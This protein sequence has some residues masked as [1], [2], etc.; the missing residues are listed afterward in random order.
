MELDQYRIKPTFITKRRIS[1]GLGGKNTVQYFT[2]R[3]EV[4]V[5]TWEHETDLEQYG[6]IVSRYYLGIGLESRYK[7]EERM[8]NIEGAE[9]KTHA[10]E[11]QG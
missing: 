6:N 1:R 5:K 11:C 7:S 3:D 10:L 9:C 4:S 2:S 8:Q